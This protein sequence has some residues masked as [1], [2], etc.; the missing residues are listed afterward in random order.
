MPEGAQILS[1][2]IQNGEVCLWALVDTEKPLKNKEIRIYGTGHP[3]EY[4]DQDAK[5]IGTVQLK[6]FVWHIFEKL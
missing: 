6:S 5:Y 1:A 3:Y 2:Q 4:T